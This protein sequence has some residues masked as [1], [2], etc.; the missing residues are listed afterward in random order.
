VDNPLC[1]PRGAAAI[2]GPQKGAS[3]EQVQILDRNLAHLADLIERDLGKNVRDFP[4]AGAAGGLGAG[5]VAFFDARLDRGINLVMDAVR[6]HE[7]IRVADLI[8]TG[9]GR[10][11]RQSMMGKVI[12]GVGR[13]GQAAG[14]PVV[15]LVGSIGEGA[16][17]ALGVLRGFHPINPPGMPLHEA[18]PRT[19][20]NLE[21][22]AALLPI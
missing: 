4:G 5:L 21:A 14:V 3:P 20:A 13:A 15:A 22:A 17:A 19:A 18:L 12:A 2:Y 16:E 8:I 10:L 11:D 9:E 6:F 1:G 7:R